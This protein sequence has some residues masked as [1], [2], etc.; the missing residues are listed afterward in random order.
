MLSGG[1]QHHATPT[2]AP[3]PFSA[4]SEPTDLPR[5]R[6][7]DCMELHPISF[8][9]GPDNARLL[10][11]THREG[12][13]ARA[14]H[15]LVI[16]ATRW[17][18]QVRIDA[19]E[20]PR[21]HVEVRVDARGLE[22]RE[23][24]GGARPLTD[25]DRLEIKTNIEEKVLHADRDPELRFA[26]EQVV[27]EDHHAHLTGDLTIGGETRPAGVDV[28]LEPAADGLHARGAIPIRQ[29]DYGIKPYS[30]LM[31]MLKVADQV[32]VDFDVRLPSEAI[33]T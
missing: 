14:G 18:G 25:K 4:S 22:V 9:I 10:I 21:G 29:T 13:G 31:G 27:V 7:V 26:A 33:S 11:R 15:D 5:R 2:D 8:E 12:L 30:A 6:N 24:H 3:E 28:D 23:G 19:G 16:E 20:P 1:R 32:E 17:T